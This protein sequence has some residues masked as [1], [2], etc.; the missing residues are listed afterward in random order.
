MTN[1]L[2]FK[3]VE[4]FL[5]TA[6]KP[7]IVLLG[8]T[9][10]G[11]T[12]ISIELAKRFSGEVISA[13]SRQIYRHFSIGTNKTT[14]EEMQGIPHHLIDFLEPHESFFAPDFQKAAF[15]KIK[16]IRNRGHLPFLVGGTMLYLDS[17]TKGFAFPEGTFDESLREKLEEK[18]TEEL[19]QQL[20]NL[21]PETFAHLEKQNRVYLIRAI[22]MALLGERKSK[23]QTLDPSLPQYDFLI[24]GVERNREELYDRINERVEVMWKNGLLDEAQ[25]II[26]KTYKVGNADLRSLQSSCGY[27]EAIA[28][29]RE[30]LSETEAKEKM[31]QSTRHYAKRQLTWWRKDDRI[32]W[33]KAK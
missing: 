24:L 20:Q 23:R 22:E 4:Q 33:I 14:N 8:A 19:Q 32:V 15:T 7:V 21:D 28:F 17:V 30:E 3:A 16:E 29:L 10:S 12:A 9:A 1:P 2:F 27:P 18:S 31:K 26:E 6:Q 11:K 13:D 5:K 25:S